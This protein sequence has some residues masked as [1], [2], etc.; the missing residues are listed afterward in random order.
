MG[1]N[2]IT[3]CIVELIGLLSEGPK[4][5]MHF[6]VS[7]SIIGLRFS[8][9]RCSTIQQL[10]ECVILLP[11]FAR[12]AFE[13]TSSAIIL[14]FNKTRHYTIF[15]NICFRT[16]APAFRL[17]ETVWLMPSYY[18]HYLLIYN[19]FTCLGHFNIKQSKSV[20]DF[21]SFF[22]SYSKNHFSYKLWRDL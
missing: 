20:I 18:Y 9:F 12:P 14:G 10:R 7:P 6:T 2:V 21:Q 4:R 1:S 22:P 11:C 5:K 15:E 19:A 8:H 3:L 13:F 17:P 16:T